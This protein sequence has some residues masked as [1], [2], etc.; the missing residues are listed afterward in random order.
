MARGVRKSTLEKLN[1]EL[2]EVRESIDRCQESLTTLKQ[3]E[4]VLLE[5]VDL[6][7]FKTITVML[8]EQGMT[9]ED[10]KV[11]VQGSSSDQ[12]SA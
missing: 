2:S 6:E 5:Q 7:E 9:L 12:Q 10:L 8:N 3:R 4:K 11:L 1:E